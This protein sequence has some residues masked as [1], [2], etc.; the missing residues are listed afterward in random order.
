MLIGGREPSSRTIT[1]L[2]STWNGQVWHQELQPMPTKRFRPGVT[3][4]QNL[5][6]VAGGLDADGQTLLSTIDILNITTLQW[7]IP[8]NF[9]LPQSMGSML[10]TISTAHL[11]VA[12]AGIAYNVATN[13]GTSTKTVWQL[14]LTALENALTTESDSMSHHW[15]EVAPT[16]NYSSVLLQHSSCSSCWWI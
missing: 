8:D 15:N 4:Y 9:R 6:L 2:T 10:F 5:V 12:S 11:Y 16:L 3:T 7:S 13:T 1:N 14:P